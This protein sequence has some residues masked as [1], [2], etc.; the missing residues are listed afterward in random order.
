V[1]Q[2]DADYNAADAGR[3][4]SIS[5][6]NAAAFYI[7][8]AVIVVGALLAVG[9]PRPREAAAGLLVVT[10]GAGILA[11]VSGA[12]LTGLVEIAVPAVAIGAVG[13]ALRRAGMVD[14]ATGRWPGAT[15]ALA[16]AAALGL[17]V[18]LLVAFSG[19][20]GSWHAG[21][22]GAAL[23][24]LLHYRAGFALVVVLVSLVVGVAGALL[25]GRVGEDEREYARTHEARRL[26]DERTQR[27]REEREAARRRRAGSLEKAP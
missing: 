13:L 1:A 15:V 6:M 4:R 14:P 8:G 17:L 18:I 26:R 19:N 21:A 24:T 7:L 5:R 12:Y 20:A 11:L 2:R 23:L 16:G 27:R 22:G 25:L 3:V 10:S 9:V